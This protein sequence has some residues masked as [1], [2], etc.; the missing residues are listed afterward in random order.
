MLISAIR[1]RRCHVGGCG[2]RTGMAPIPRGR[3]CLIT[4]PTQSEKRPF[5]RAGQ[6]DVLSSAHPRGPARSDRECRPQNQ[7]ST[8]WTRAAAQRDLSRRTRS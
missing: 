8:R 6:P 2:R 3:Q 1:R 7:S 5:E 4:D